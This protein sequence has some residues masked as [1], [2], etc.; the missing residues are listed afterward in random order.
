MLRISR[1]KVR[2]ASEILKSVEIKP[3]DLTDVR[4]YPPSGEP[5]ERVLRYFIALVAIDHRTS[6]PNYRY[7][8]LINDEYYHG[9]DL[10]YRLGMRMYLKNPEFYSPENLAKLSYRSALNWLRT[11]DGKLPTN[12]KLRVRLLRDL[13]WKLQQLYDGNVTEL[14]RRAGHRALGIDGILN[15]LRTFLAYQDPV[16]KKANLF[17]K[18]LIRRGV[19]IRDPWNVAVPV[20]NHLT[21][22]A[23]RLGLV[24][25]DKPLLLTVTWKRKATWDEDVILRLAVKKA[26]KLMSKFSEKP[27]H[28]LDDFLWVHGR[29]VCTR[30]FPKCGSCLFKRVCMAHLYGNANVLKEHLY[31]NTWYY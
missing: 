30:I 18:F 1:K 9:A 11:P 16:E 26:Y 13:G 17:L 24:R 3:F 29:K 10:L 19:K 25:I 15:R 27:Q 23:V 12:V 14:L 31:Y 20:D 28:I 5:L 21:R 2:E 7:E 6:R 22:I 4:Y 8:A